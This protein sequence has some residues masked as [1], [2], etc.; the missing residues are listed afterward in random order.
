MLVK[1]EN[2]TDTDN[3]VFAF[4]CKMFFHKAETSR[5]NM[6]NEQMLSPIHYKRG[7]NDPLSRI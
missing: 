2:G 3:I 4:K 1:V 7:D 5:K 6:H